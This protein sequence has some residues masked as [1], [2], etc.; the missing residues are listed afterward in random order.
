MLFIF[1]ILQAVRGIGNKSKEQMENTQNTTSGGT[2]YDKGKSLILPYVGPQLPT[3][4]KWS[5]HFYNST[6][7]SDNH[8]R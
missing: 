7:L 3:P 8:P 2:T 4:H 1:P 5:C 6:Y